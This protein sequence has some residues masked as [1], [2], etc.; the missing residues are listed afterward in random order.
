MDIGSF[1]FNSA[2][3]PNTVLKELLF[4]WIW[5]EMFQNLT[6]P[7]DMNK[8]F[9]QCNKKCLRNIFSFINFHHFIAIDAELASSNLNTE[10]TKMSKLME[11]IKF[12]YQTGSKTVSE[13]QKYLAFLLDTSLGSR[14]PGQMTINRRNFLDYEEEFLCAC[15]LITNSMKKN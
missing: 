15:S 11:D 4:E 6:K 13:I 12:M 8:V 2:L 7:I 1:S 10:T 9:L 3:T 14:I 5:Y